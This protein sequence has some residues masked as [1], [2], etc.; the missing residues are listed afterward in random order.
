MKLLKKSVYATRCQKKAES[1]AIEFNQGEIETE[2]EIGER[3]G[4]N[5][6]PYGDDMWV[7]MLRDSDGTELGTL[8]FT[9]ELVFDENGSLL[10]CK[11]S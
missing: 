11:M 6:E 8:P 7:V 3:W 9:T 1:A 4:A 10:S 2:P 5:V